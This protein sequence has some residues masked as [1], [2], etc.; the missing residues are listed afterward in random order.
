MRKLGVE[1]PPPTLHRRGGPV[2]EVLHFLL[3]F[4]AMFGGALLALDVLF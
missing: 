1:L 4:G 2:K 3:A